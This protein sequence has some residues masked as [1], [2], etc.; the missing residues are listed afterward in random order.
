MIK[1]NMPKALI[2]WHPAFCSAM[3]LDLSDANPDSCLIFEREHTLNKAPLQ[4]DLLV[5]RE[6]SAPLHGEIGEYLRR[7][8]LFEFKSQHS[9]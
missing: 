3:E 6:D 2:Q 8:N 7:Y 1:Q 9:Q 5:T 4:V